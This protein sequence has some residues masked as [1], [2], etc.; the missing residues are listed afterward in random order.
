MI[1][2]FD[3]IVYSSAYNKDGLQ[4]LLEAK[5]L[6]IPILSYP[7]ALGELSRKYY[8]IGIAGSHGKT[9]TT[10]FLGVLLIN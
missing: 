5:E 4:V 9:T 10:A 2:L 7:E 8:S 3:L 1:G 6:N